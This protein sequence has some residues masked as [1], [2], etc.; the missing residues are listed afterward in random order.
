M[1][2]HIFVLVIV[3]FHCD[4]V[5]VFRKPFKKSQW[6]FYS[7][8]VCLK[9]RQRER[10]CVHVY[11]SIAL[12]CYERRKAVSLVLCLTVWGGQA[13]EIIN[14]GLDCVHVWG[15]LCI[16]SLYMWTKETKKETEKK[17]CKQMYLFV[18]ISAFLQDLCITQ[19]SNPVLLKVKTPAV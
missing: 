3:A 16:P 10:V 5:V 17:R 18:L 12:P 14:L 11:F 6:L 15:C 7:V 2:S 19:A 8:Q 13:D 9:I 1:N 4:L